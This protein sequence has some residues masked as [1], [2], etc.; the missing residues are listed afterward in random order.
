MSVITIIFAS[1]IY[2]ILNKSSQI[3]N[4]KRNTITGEHLVTFYETQ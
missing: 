3:I 4:N 2:F 1:V